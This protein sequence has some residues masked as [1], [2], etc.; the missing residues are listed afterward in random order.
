MPLIILVTILGCGVEN[1][2][3]WSTKDEWRSSTLRGGPVCYVHQLDESMGASHTFVV[4]DAL[5]EP[6]NDTLNGIV[7]SNNGSTEITLIP[8]ITFLDFKKDSCG[9][10]DHDM[11]INGSCVPHLPQAGTK[12][13]EDYDPTGTW[14]GLGLNRL[15]V[16]FFYYSLVW[17]IYKLTFLPI[18]WPDRILK[19]ATGGFMKEPVFKLFM[20]P[21][22]ERLT[23]ATDIISKL[24]ACFRYVMLPNTLLKPLI[25]MGYVEECPGL[26]HY[27]MDMYL[28]QVIY[29][30][31]FSDLMFTGFLF[32][33]GH[34]LYH[35][36]VIGSW[37]Y[38][39]YKVWWFITTP[40]AFILFIADIIITSDMR[41]WRG[42]T[43]TLLANFT[44]DIEL[45]LTFFVDLTQALGSVVFIL[46]TV[47]LV[48][49]ILCLV[50][51]KCGQ[52]VPV[53][54]QWIK[55]D[56]EAEE[57]EDKGLLG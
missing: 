16:P 34:T 52:K 49:L 33:L 23:K 24:G 32:V 43:L 21:Y 56:E 10:E 14:Q 28:G 27:I 3:N 40:I 45:R 7:E 44:F 26:Y 39:L 13:I 15:K 1:R 42:F 37:C 25:T 54:K 36:S 50:C 31:C 47:Q 51:P 11:S 29:F 38:S 2:I 19:C 18:H 41:F 22:F 5:V 4:P 48:V 20:T 12:H 6:F 53:V 35:N 30:W 46:D 55:D 57:E 8:E 17:G 9:V